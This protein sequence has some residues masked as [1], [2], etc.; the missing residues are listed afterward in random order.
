M[1]DAKDFAEVARKYLENTNM[2]FSGEEQI[3]QY[4]SPHKSFEETVGVPA[5][6]NM[7]VIESNGISTKSWRNAG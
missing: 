1:Q 5:I 7:H 6:F 3:H 4:I 2:I